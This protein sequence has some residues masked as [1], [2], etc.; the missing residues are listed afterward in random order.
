MRKSFS[1]LTSIAPHLLSM[2]PL[3]VH[4]FVFCNRQRNRI[5]VLFWDDTGLWV[6]AKRLEKGRFSWPDHVE[7]RS[8]ISTQQLAL[9]LDGLIVAL[10]IASSNF[11]QPVSPSPRILDMD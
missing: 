1:G 11:A 7:D 2:G 6:C 5:K 4:L 10:A 8:V 3:S 9:H